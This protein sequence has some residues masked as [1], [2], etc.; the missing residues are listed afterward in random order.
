MLP[1]QLIGPTQIILGAWKNLLRHSRLYA[2]FVA[3]ITAIT[4]MLWGV[5]ALSRS[6]IADQT[7]ASA[8]FLIAQ[9]PASLVIMA[10]TAA[11]IDATAKTLQ[12]R[13]PAFLE[14]LNV[15][16]HRLISLVWVSFLTSAVVV[17]GPLMA[18][19]V[20]LAVLRWSPSGWA[21]FIG[22][23]LLLPLAA[24]LL[25]APPLAYLIRFAFAPEFLVMDGVRGRQALAQ[26]RQLV[27]GRWWRVFLRLAVPALFFLLASRLAVAVTYLVIGSVLGD[28]GLFF[29][30]ADLTALP[31][32]HVLIIT[33]V[34]S[35]IYGFSAP[36]Y[37]AA[38]LLL[39]FDLKSTPA[40]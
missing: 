22:Y 1:N 6:L 3:W 16:I 34:P 27:A 19:A 18:V 11:I 5:G 17:I 7:A 20:F 28:P 36:L 29:G 37:V 32:F 40:S 33:V 9:L 39:W 25:A 2:E 4:L 24:A 38:N 10:L 8:V 13:R 12:K 21:A 35:V 23:G 31:A 30:P 15:G 26:S 14:S